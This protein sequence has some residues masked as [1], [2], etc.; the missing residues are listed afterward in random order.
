MA[1]NISLHKVYLK[2]LDKIYQNECLTSILDTEEI[3]S[4]REAKTFTVD[5]M[6]MDGLGRLFIE[7]EKLKKLVKEGSEE[8]VFKWNKGY[9]EIFN[10]LDKIIYE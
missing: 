4:T 5:K 8:V 6:E 2:S 1:N 9:Q 3:D 10:L 7:Y